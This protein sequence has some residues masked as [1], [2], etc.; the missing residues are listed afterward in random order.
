MAVPICSRVARQGGDAGGQPRHGMVTLTLVSTLS[1]CPTTE[2][3]EGM[4]PA[5][6]HWTASSWCRSTWTPL[7]L[8][9]PD[10]AAAR[11]CCGIGLLL[12]AL[13]GSELA[14][15]VMS[16]AGTANG[17]ALALHS[18]GV[19]AAWAASAVIQN[20]C[21]RPWV[22]WIGGAKKEPATGELA[23]GGL[24]CA[25]W[26]LA[27]LAVT[28]ESLVGLADPCRHTP[29][30]ACCG[31]EAGAAAADSASTWPDAAT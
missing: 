7:L 4:E 20:S 10:R 21:C 28:A 31:G 6:C 30:A 13:A 12:A 26:R 18:P 8:Q 9:L 24:C 14:V 23:S 19:P 1:L 16:R 3:P 15:R 25:L 5:S 2:G 22:G 27:G 11:S 29:G 17:S